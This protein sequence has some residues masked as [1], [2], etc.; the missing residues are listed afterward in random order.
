MAQERKA[1]LYEKLVRGELSDEEN[2]EKYCIDFFRKGMEQE[3]EQPQASDASVTVATQDEARENDAPMLFDM[4]FV[5]PGR[6][7]GTMD[8]NDHKRFVSNPLV[9]SE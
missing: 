3:S 8:N 9:S 6:T 1:D 5:A 4:K 7:I 2:K